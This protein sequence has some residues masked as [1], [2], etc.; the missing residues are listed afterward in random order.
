MHRIYRIKK[1]NGKEIVQ[2]VQRGKPRFGVNQRV[3][4]L[5]FNTQFRKG[6]IQT[7]TSQIYRIKEVLD[8]FPYTY[9]V[10]HEESGEPVEG[11]FYKEELIAIE[12]E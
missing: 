5:R 3:R 11:I 2:P 6:Y 8:T 1:Y 10:I 7:F 9:S 4:L 12:N